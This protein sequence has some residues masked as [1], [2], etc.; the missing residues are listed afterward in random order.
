[1]LK[2]CRAIRAISSNSACSGLPLI[3]PS[4]ASGSRMNIGE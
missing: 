3:D 4:V 2:S 1:M